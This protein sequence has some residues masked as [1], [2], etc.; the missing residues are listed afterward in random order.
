MSSR[1]VPVEAS[2]T[3]RRYELRA[4]L[5]GIDPID[6]LRLTCTGNELRIDAM[7]VPPWRAGPGH[8]EFTYGRRLRVVPLPPGVRP[9][10]IA[11]CYVDG[12]LEVTAALGETAPSTRPF[13]VDVRAA[14]RRSRRPVTSGPDRLAPA[15]VP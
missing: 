10:T 7:R 11:A 9:G 5:P 13:A 1:A 4:E 6:D 15:G 12:V 2:V 8:S 14:P 3:D